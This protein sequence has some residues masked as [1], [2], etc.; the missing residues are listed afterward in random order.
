MADGI[1]VVCPCCQTKLTVDAASGEIL[2]EERPRRT[3]S[4]EEALSELRSS[5]RKREDAFAKAFERTRRLDEILEKKF[6]E[7]QKKTE[8]D[9][10]PPVNPLDLD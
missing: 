2:S 4:F 10:A 8:G 1:Q 7:A 9:T 6:K 3:K 5:S